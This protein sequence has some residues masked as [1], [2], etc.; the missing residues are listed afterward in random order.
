MQPL[1]RGL[2]P[3]R[4]CASFGFGAFGVSG[5]EACVLHVVQSVEAKAF[6]FCLILKAVVWKLGSIAVPSLVYLLQPFLAEHARCWT[7][8]ISLGGLR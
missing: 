6:G 8:C 4:A 3:S 5:V 2:S 1:G 7:F